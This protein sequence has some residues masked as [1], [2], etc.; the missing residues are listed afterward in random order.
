MKVLFLVP[1]PTEG[2]SNRFR[3]EQYFP[4]LKANRVDCDL[5]PFWDK[6]AY[7]ILYKDGHYFRKFCSFIKGNI[8]RLKELSQVSAYDVV[9]IHREACP[10]GGAYLERLAAKK[11]P[12][13]FDFDDA[14]FLSTISNANRIAGLLKTPKK[15]EKILQCSTAVIVGNNYL[16]DYALN[17]NGDVNVI[18]TPIDA[19]SYLPVS[20]P[21]GQKK[22]ITIGW[23]GS[24]TNN[25]YLNIVR[26]VL[27]KLMIKYG[28][29]LDIVLV[30]CKNEFLKIKG[31][32]YRDWSLSREISDLQSFDIG[33][34]PIW[35]DEWTQGKC[36]F[37]I[38]QYMSVG[39]CVVASP[40][41]MN[42]YIISDGVNG[43][44]AKDDGEWLDKLTIL[45]EQP[46]L[47][48][49]FASEGRITIENNYSLKVT[50]P[51]LLSVLKKVCP[52]N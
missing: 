50:A 37:K 3:V 24:Y 10:V 8:N 47:R 34:M 1:Y 42:K 4:Y 36:A 11:K 28:D 52:G 45:I 21:V 22:K 48:R 9:F 18:P 15:T 33:I 30:G 41:G 2:P 49:K 31:V 40:V 43:F 5:R 25:Q 39:A 44:L 46:E 29:S 13:V 7:K 35:D 17:F 14:I 32:I 38:I 26:D 27:M 51:K 19:D 20:Q 23:I 12:V 6:E 16:R